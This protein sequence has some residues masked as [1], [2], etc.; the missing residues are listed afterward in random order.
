MTSDIC[1]VLFALGFALSVSGSQ[2]WAQPGDARADQTDVDSDSQ[3]E[4]DS[5][6]QPSD[7]EELERRL[8]ILAEEVERLRSG[9]EESVELT[10]EQ[11][12]ALGLAPSAA[13]TYERG[14]GVSLAGYGEM[15]YERFSNENQ[16]GAPSGRTSRIDFLRAI[17]YA[18]YRFNDK[19]LFN[20]EIE[21]EHANEVSV[22]FA[23]IDYLV[24]ENLGV[25]GGL[26]LLP[27]GLVN[28]FHEPTVFLGAERPVTEQ[29]IIPS[30]WRENGGGVHG[31]SGS[32]SYRAYVVNGLDGAGFS[33]NG[34]RGGRQKGAK[35][36]AENFAF[37][38][39]LD[40]T[41]TPGIFAGVSIYSGGSGQG[42]VVADGQSFSVQTTIFDVHGQAQIRGF[43]IR[44][45]FANASIG[46]AVQLNNVLGNT[47]TSGVAEQMRGGY[48]QVGYNVLSQRSVLG[49]AA[50][51]PY[52]R[53]ERVDTQATMPVGFDRSRSTDNTFNTIGVEVKPIPN[54]VVKGD[55]TW[56][57]NDAD[58]G[59][60]QFSIGLG[61]VF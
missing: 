31:S 16:A 12:R 10:D 14:R 1:R 52:Y 11:V 46:D 29:R 30:T 2:A 35:A 25:R 39:R 8:E 27:L 23:Y 24:H 51:T 48:A 28:E 38:G 5:S 47:G 9:E 37:A 59:V 53:W 32:L 15:L 57:G 7:L 58:T 60:D 4:A 3:T 40:I 21:I 49:G 55:Y 36:K 20:S 43:D 18:G 61:Y 13:R 56:V 19:F 50:L 42:D 22:E 54:I 44:G 17:I 34:I 6:E 26:V 45:L 41:P 33:A